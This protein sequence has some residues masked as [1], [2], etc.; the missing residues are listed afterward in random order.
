MENEVGNV[1]EV[2]SALAAMPWSFCLIDSR[3]PLKTGG[4]SDISDCSFGR[5]IREHL[6]GSVG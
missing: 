4:P 2:Q 1:G 3:E 6:G 5:F